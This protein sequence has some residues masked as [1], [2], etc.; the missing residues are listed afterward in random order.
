MRRRR[1]RRP[2]KKEKPIID[3]IANE[4]IAFDEIR[5]IDQHGEMI[6]VMSPRS[7][8]KNAQDAELDLVVVNPKATP[9]VAKII[10]VNKYKYEQEKERRS[11]KGKKVEVKGVR[12]S[13]RISENDL[14]F[15][16]RMA[17]K[18]LSQGHKVRIELMLR[19]RE[20]GNKEYALKSFDRFIEAMDTPVVAEQEAKDQRLGLAMIVR[21]DEQALKARREAAKKAALEELPESDES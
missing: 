9:P 15:K 4:D 1:R 17:D 13:I 18:F 3:I 11:K 19:G 8:M 12:I 16:S 6:G 2:Q 5:V 20:R 14:A 21:T 10:D 7:A